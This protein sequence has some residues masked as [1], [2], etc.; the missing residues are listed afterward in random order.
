[1]ATIDLVEVNEKIEN[2]VN[3]NKYMFDLPIQ[4]VG[5][6]IRHFCE[7]NGIEMDS[8]E[9]KIIMDMM[10]QKMLNTFDLRLNIEMLRGGRISDVDMYE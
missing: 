10:R 7:M 3:Q 6:E 4:E 1:M 9:Y 8:D 5:S 2:V